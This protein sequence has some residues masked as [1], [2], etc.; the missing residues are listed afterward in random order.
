M[1][2]NNGTETGY[3]ICMYGT[4]KSNLYKNFI[5]QWWIQP[6]CMDVKYG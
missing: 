5:K 4:M 6:V 3:N 2:H 1:P